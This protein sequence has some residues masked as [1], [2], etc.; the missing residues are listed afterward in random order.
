M[1]SARI[2]LTIL[3][4]GVKAGVGTSTLQGAYVPASQNWLIGAGVGPTT[5]IICHLKRIIGTIFYKN[6]WANR[7]HMFQIKSLLTYRPLRVG[8]DSLSGCAT[9][10]VAKKL[11]PTLFLERLGKEIIVMSEV[12]I[13]VILACIRYK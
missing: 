8:V 1:Q 9:K 13:V 7:S 5:P 12:L 6:V 11:R 2:Q 3:Q 4:E 10:F